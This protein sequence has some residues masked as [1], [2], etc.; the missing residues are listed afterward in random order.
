MRQGLHS[1]TVSVLALARADLRAILG[2]ASLLAVFLTACHRPSD[3]QGLYVNQDGSGT[4]FPCNDPAVQM[5]VQDSALERRYHTAVTPGAAAFVR[6]RGVKGHSG[7]I[8]GGQRLLT[9]QQILEIRP[10]TVADCPD[11]AHPV[12]SVLSESH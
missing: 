4:F 6:L 7:S 1:L 2:R 12:G 8:Y 10:R 9:V 3:V 11:V 5:V